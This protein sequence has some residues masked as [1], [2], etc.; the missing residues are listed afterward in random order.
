MCCLILEYFLNLAKPFSLS[1]TN[2]RLSLTYFPSEVHVHNFNFHN[3]FLLSSNF[4]YSFPFPN[5][6]SNVVKQLSFIKIFFYTVLIAWDILLCNYL[7]ILSLILHLYM[8]V[9]LFMQINHQLKSFTS[10]WNFS[11]Q[12]NGHQ[13]SVIFRLV[14]REGI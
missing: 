12:G 9:C 10:F 13:Y 3:F 14:H 4:K 5:F 8:E 2:L 7:E 6:N 1:A 11:C